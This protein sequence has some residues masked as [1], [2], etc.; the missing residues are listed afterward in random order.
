MTVKIPKAPASVSGKGQEARLRE[1]A[2]K[3][4]G[5]LAVKKLQT[6]PSLPS[7]FPPIRDED[8]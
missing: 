5:S 3:L 8:Y 2:K 7:Y 4:E 1:V 6:P